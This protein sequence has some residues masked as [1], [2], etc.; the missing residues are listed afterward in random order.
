M[1]DWGVAPSSRWSARECRAAV[2]RR[3][4]AGYLADGSIESFETDEYEG[5]IGVLRE[6]DARGLHEEGGTE[7]ESASSVIMA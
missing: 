4:R 7:S 3:A 1:A 5:D 6:L 2:L